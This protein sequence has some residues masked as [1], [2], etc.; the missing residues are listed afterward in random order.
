MA[1]SAIVEFTGGLL[2]VRVDA[3]LDGGSPITLDS[4]AEVDE[5]KLGQVVLTVAGGRTLTGKNLAHKPEWPKPVGNQMVLYID[6]D[7]PWALDRVHVNTPDGDLSLS[8]PEGLVT[9]GGFR[10]AANPAVPVTNDSFWAEDQHDRIGDDYSILFVACQTGTDPADPLALGPSDP[11]IYTKATLPNP[12]NTRYPGAVRAFATPEKAFQALRGT[13]STFAPRERKYAILYEGSETITSRYRAGLTDPR[14][15]CP[16]ATR[17]TKPVVID[18]YNCDANHEVVVDW[19]TGA[20]LAL[21]DGRGWGIAIGGGF[22][23]LEAEHLF[24]YDLGAPIITLPQDIQDYI[25]MGRCR[26]NKARNRGIFILNPGTP[27]EAWRMEKLLIVEPVIDQYA[28]NGGTSN[29]SGFSIDSAIM[30]SGTPAVGP[31]EIVRAALGEHLGVASS[32]RHLHYVKGPTDRGRFFGVVCKNIASNG[33]PKSDGMAT[34]YFRFGLIG[35]SGGGG[36][37]SVNMEVNIGYPAFYGTR[38]DRLDAGPNTAGRN[39]YR[40]YLGDW[41]VMGSSGIRFQSSYEDL[42]ENILMRGAGTSNGKGPSNSVNPGAGGSGPET[43]GEGFRSVL[44]RFVVFLTGMGNGIQVNPPDSDTP[45]DNGS[46]SLHGQVYRD[47]IVTGTGMLRAVRVLD[48]IYRD[49]YDAGAISVHLRNLTI[50]DPTGLTGKFIDKDRVA[51][52]TYDSIADFA[53]ATR[54]LLDGTSDSDDPQLADP[55]RT[56]DTYAALLGYAD[57]GAMWDAHRDGVWTG[58]MPAGLREDQIANYLIAGY[59]PTN[60][61]VLAKGRELAFWGGAAADDS[62]TI[63]AVRSVRGLRA[64]RWHR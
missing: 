1:D 13:L 22:R 44:R 37:A 47:G 43:C 21:F 34:A 48:H 23:V 45:T 16:Y 19:G 55:T 60:P 41:I 25:F 5:S 35:D 6:M 58:T 51:P 29:P 36:S 7:Y 2:C 14:T 62:P 39:S 46:I 61:V 15:Y 54:D 64:L 49:K 12:G 56:F 17:R 57:Q 53:A 63:T 50:H 9:Q 38:V 27:T 18:T 8:L 10:S 28:D 11:A 20:N 30:P 33:G 42:I 40:N 31:F 3:P 52:V 26:A 59:L 4:T 24:R 32:L